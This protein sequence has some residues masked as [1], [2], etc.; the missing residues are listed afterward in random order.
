MPCFS[1]LVAL[2]ANGTTVVQVRLVDEG[3][4]VFFRPKRFDS[5]SPTQGLAPRWS[6]HRCR[7]L[8]MA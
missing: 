5:S 7:S 1:M 3:K 4:S 8:S 2:L 6:R